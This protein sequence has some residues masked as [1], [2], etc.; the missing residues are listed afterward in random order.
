M[1]KI[2]IAAALVAL[3]AGGLS[4]PAPVGA[5]TLAVGVGDSTFDPATL[6]VAVGDTVTW[7]VSSGMPHTVTADDGAF[8]SGTLTDGDTFSF[9]FDTPG[10]YPYYCLFHGAP[11]GIGMSGVVVVEAA[12]GTTT[13][14]DG[15]GTEPA[16][17]GGGGGDGGSSPST[18]MPH[19]GD[20]QMGTASPLY[21]G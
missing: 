17:G 6:T 21:T 7:T 3:I 2:A 16:G 11:G 19:G 9:T 14:I 13:T 20:P 1:R 10:T 15:G 5:A 18:S 4:M 8:D 12:G